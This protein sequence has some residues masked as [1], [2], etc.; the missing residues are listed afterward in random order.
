MVKTT[1]FIYTAFH[2]LVI[3][4]SLLYSLYYLR[5]IRTVDYLK[6]FPLYTVISLAVD[7]T[8]YF[9]KSLGNLEVNIFLFLEFIFFYNFYWKILNDKKSRIAI[10]FLSVMYLV[11]V[12][13]MLYMYINSSNYTFFVLLKKRSFIELMALDNIFIVIPAILYYKVLFL[14]PIKKLKEN[15]IFLIVTGILIGFSI[16]IPVDAMFWVIKSYDI[17]LFLYLYILNAFGYII[18]HYCFI[19]SY[20]LLK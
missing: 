14:S 7:L 16:M 20:K 12:I 17:N 11:L 13:V 8:F 9:N 6:Y 19:K 3:F 2:D 1:V 15:P 5:K 4:I 10:I 18:I